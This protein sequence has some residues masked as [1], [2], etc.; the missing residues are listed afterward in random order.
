MLLGS[1]SGSSYDGGDAEDGYD[2]DT[3]REFNLTKYGYGN[4]RYGEFS[5]HRKYFN[6]RPIS[7]FPTIV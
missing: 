3:L 1:S 6:V 5:Y 7:T 2:S 4:K